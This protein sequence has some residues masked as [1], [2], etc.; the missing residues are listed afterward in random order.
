MRPSE[1]GSRRFT[2]IDRVPA[3]EPNPYEPPESEPKPEGRADP[4]EPAG[5]EDNAMLMIVLGVGLV[6]T[7][8][9]GLLSM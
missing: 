5:E 7:L 9:A 4:S 1:G 6:L 2:D 8:I 3:S